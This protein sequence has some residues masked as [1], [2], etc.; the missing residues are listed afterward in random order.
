MQPQSSI[1]I[2]KLTVHVN[3]RAINILAPVN[4]PQPP[5]LANK[6]QSHKVL[7]KTA[8]LSSIRDHS[9]QYEQSHSTPDDFYENAK[10]RYGMDN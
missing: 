6:N 4:V 10:S 5:R 3:D 9:L 7:P 1:E 8:K 2:R